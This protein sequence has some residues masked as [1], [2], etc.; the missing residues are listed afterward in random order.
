MSYLDLK[1]T[2]SWSIPLVMP[3]TS[4]TEITGIAME[5]FYSFCVCL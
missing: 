1:I 4:L 2:K 3:C 5:Q